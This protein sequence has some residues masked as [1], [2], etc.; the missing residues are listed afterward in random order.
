MGY[1]V[2]H[3][4]K[5]VT[6]YTRRVSIKANRNGLKATMISLAAEF[7][8]PLLV[9]PADVAYSEENDKV[10]WLEDMAVK[11]DSF[12]SECAM[13]LDS[14]K[15]SMT[16]V[17]PHEWFDMPSADNLFGFCKTNQKLYDVFIKVAYII[18]VKYI[19]GEISHDGE[20]ADF[21]TENWEVLSVEEANQVVIF[22][23]DFYLEET[24]ALHGIT[25]PA[26]IG[27]ELASA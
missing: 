21:L 16:I 13:W 3:E 2:Y 12:T 25:I 27:S 17:G 5:D 10:T 26:L 18:A 24:C 4:I 14:E 8:V 6:D 15:F 11:T 23:K 7:E 20:P 9:C 19:G 22:L 1:T